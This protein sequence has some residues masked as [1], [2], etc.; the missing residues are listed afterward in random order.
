MSSA[1]IP[2]TSL[3]FD[4]SFKF[5]DVTPSEQ[6]DLAA[7]DANQSVTFS[8]ASITVIDKTNTLA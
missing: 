1:A 4:A 8:D 3:T 5:A 7:N 6:D 2:T